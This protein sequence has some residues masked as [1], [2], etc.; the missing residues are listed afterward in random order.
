[1]LSINKLYNDYKL[2]I[3][4]PDENLVVGLK[5]QT[6]SDNIYDMIVD[7]IDESKFDEDKYDAL[8]DYDKL[9][10]KMIVK[11]CNLAGD[12][13]IRLDRLNNDDIEKLKEDFNIVMGQLESGNDNPELN[14][15]AKALI[16]EMLSKKVISNNQ[17]LNLL[18]DL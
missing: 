2:K 16:N 3:L 13:N 9:L 10:Y 8:N 1:M 5:Y 4:Y 6:V 17:A 7:I 11:K 14:K 15:K 12:L 18:K